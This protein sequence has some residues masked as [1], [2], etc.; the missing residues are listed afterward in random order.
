MNGSTHSPSPMLFFE[1][2]NAYQRSAAL[3][4]AVDLGLFTAIGPDGATAVEAS[5]TC[6]ASERGTR[7]LCDYLVVIGFL[8]KQDG[9]YALTPD[10]ALFLD[11]NSHAYMGGALAFLHSD[12]IMEAF[13]HLTE[14]ARKGGT[15]LPGSGTVEDEHPVWAAFARAMMPMMM[16]PALGVAECVRCAPD[17]PVRVLDV[18]AGHGI[19]GI[20]LAQRYPNV[21][22]VA[23]DWPHVLDVAAENAKRM[24]VADRHRPLPGSA[25]D[26]DFGTGYDLVLLTNFLH[27]FDQ[28]TIEGLLRKVHAALAEGGRAVTVDFVLNEDRVSPPE[29]AGFSLT[30]LAS[31]P[32]G[33]AYTFR[34]YETMFQNAGFAR[35]ERHPLPSSPFQAIL[36]YK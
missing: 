22:V 36:S 28:P 33:E 29:S 1:T 32:T 14:A 24:G 3:K 17:R 31:T 5:Q 19:Y 8:T 2:A 9:R 34:E 26:L 25:F 15:T 35:S 7:I 18:A 6:G 11:R 21:E 23:L 4:A 13:R 30:M 12:T 10:T 20:A 16:A 27:H